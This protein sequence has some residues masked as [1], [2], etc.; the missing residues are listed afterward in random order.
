MRSP[1]GTR[2]RCCSAGSPV[3]CVGVP[4]STHH[5]SST[6][7]ARVERQLW[8]TK[9]QRREG[10]G[11]QR[12]SSRRCQK[13]STIPPP[14]STVAQALIFPGLGKGPPVMGLFGLVFFRVGVQRSSHLRVE[15][16]IPSHG[17]RRDQAI[18][19]NP[20]FLTLC[21][22]DCTEACSSLAQYAGFPRP[23]AP[24]Y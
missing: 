17:G 24:D 11:Q 23:R 7:R 12:S 2:P 15:G 10:A 1:F 14:C 5:S 13:C 9:C 8:Y 20:C 22:R 16:I 19:P 18:I 6:G 21:S 4:S 3:H